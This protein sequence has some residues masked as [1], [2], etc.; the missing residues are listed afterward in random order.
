MTRIF[1][2]TINQVNNVYCP[3][4]RVETGDVTDTLRGLQ[5]GSKG[6]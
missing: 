4:S 6:G 1:V 5:L 3:G 2:K